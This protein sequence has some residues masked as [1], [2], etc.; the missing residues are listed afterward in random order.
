M[1]RRIAP[2]QCTLSEWRSSFCVKQMLQPSGEEQHRRDQHQ[3]QLCKH[4]YSV[5]HQSGTTSP[6]I[7]AL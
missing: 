6:A 1:Y 5:D 3:Q 2:R 7:A 4:M